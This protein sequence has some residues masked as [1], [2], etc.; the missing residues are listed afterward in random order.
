M[1]TNAQAMISTRDEKIAYKIKLRQFCEHLLHERI[2][3]TREAM[4]NAQA[5][6]NAEEKSSAGDKYETSRALSHLE[7]D[8]HARQ[9][10]A[11]TEQLSALLDINVHEVYSTAVAGSFI[12]C[13]HVNIFV[14]AG[15]AKHAVNGVDIIFISPN[16]PLARK[17]AGKKNGDNF[18]MNGTNKIV[19][20]F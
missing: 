18:E 16:S 11:H 1:E 8:M 10:L 3:A 20:I 5:A 4:A 12:R 9:L 2:S 13:E 6:A 17:L 7:K 15:L 14:A 19:D